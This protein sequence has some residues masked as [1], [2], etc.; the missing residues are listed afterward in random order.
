MRQFIVDHP[1]ADL[2]L[3]RLAARCRMSPRHLTRLFRAEFG[4]SPAHYVEG[5]RLDIA[6]RML[7]ETEQT[8]DAIALACGFGSA[9][10]LRRAFHRRVGASPAQYRRGFAAQSSLAS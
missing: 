3:T 10:T 9:E 2:S 1:Q 6:R 4:M 5:V 8:V 7:E